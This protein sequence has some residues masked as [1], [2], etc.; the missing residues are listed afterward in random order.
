MSCEARQLKS[1]GIGQPTA[2]DVVNNRGQCA[3]IQIV[4]LGEYL[5]RHFYCPIRRS[6]QLADL[7]AKLVWPKNQLFLKARSE[8]TVAGSR[9]VFEVRL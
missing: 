5:P 8:I 7:L 6:P 4:G 9:C 3:S 1:G 2:I